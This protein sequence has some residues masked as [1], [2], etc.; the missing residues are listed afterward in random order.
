MP[1]P[2]PTP[3]FDLDSACFGKRGGSSVAFKKWGSEQ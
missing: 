2:V 1:V 3:N